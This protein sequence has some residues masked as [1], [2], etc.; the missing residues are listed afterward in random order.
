MFTPTSLIYAVSILAIF[1]IFTTWIR[2]KTRGSDSTSVFVTYA[3]PQFVIFGGS[4]VFGY[5][6]IEIL[7]M[8]AAGTIG[9]GLFYSFLEEPP[10]R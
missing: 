3:S 6:I 2:E 8:I 7:F 4:L 10:L 1:F 9:S 5:N